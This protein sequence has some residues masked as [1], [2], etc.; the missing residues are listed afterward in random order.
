MP[1]HGTSGR[2]KRRWAARA[3]VAAASLAVV[4]AL[5]AVPNASPAYANAPVVDALDGS[6]VSVESVAAGR[7]D[8]FT[9]G[10]DGA[11]HQK[12]YVNGVWSGWE[13]LGGSLS[14]AP[15]VVAWA[16][17][18]NVFARSTSNT[19]VH[20]W[21]TGGAWSEWEDLGGTLTSAPSAASWGSGHIDV[22]ARG[23]DNALVHKFY[24]RG[25]SS[26]SSLGGAL[27]SA[28]SAI[29]W[30]TGRLDVFARSTGSTLTHWWYT[31]DTWFGSEDLGGS[32]TSAPAAASWT[33][34]RL[35]VFGRGSSNTLAH[36]WFTDGVWSSWEAFAGSLT[37]APSA[38]SWGT[39]RIDVF[40][41]DT[42]G[43]LQQK[44]YTGQ[45]TGW[46]RIAPF[47]PAVPI[48]SNSRTSVFQTSPGSAV[49]GTVE[50]AYT[51]NIGRLLHV[52]QTNPGDFN[53]AQWTVLSGNEAFSGQ[54]A[55]AQQ[56]DGRVQVAGHN[57][58]GDVWLRTQTQAGSPGWAAAV[59]AGGWM[60]STAT[61][62]TLSDGRL[63]M[64]AVD[65][66]GRLWYKQQSTVNGV[67]GTWQSL[68]DIDLAT[69]PT[70]A[71]SRNGLQLFGV[72]TGG[73]LRTAE[74]TSGGTVS[75]WTTLHA[76]STTG[77]PAVVVYPGFLTRVFVRTSDGAVVTKLQDSTG[78]W[79][80]S[81]QPTGTF[82]SVGSPA[83][84]LDPV[85]GRTAVVVR[86][87]DNEVYV[88]WETAQAS[89]AWGGWARAIR[90]T[91][92]TFSDPAVTDPSV[93]QVATSSGQTWI[94]VFRTI[95]DET[96]VYQRESQSA[97]VA[98][99]QAATA[100]QADF[101][102]HTLPAPPA[103]SR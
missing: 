22:F 24:L 66:D 43:D 64:F 89:G 53:L 36:R 80:A 44:T 5:V 100:G 85:L 78:S 71:V 91:D 1:E 86:G 18:F 77:T 2:T 29:S 79:P 51:D 7:L 48:Q 3:L 94:I 84:I 47:A 56:A 13:D 54:P 101:T 10:P 59:D 40:T 97:G 61:V 98:S 30:G 76:S 6:V 69:A 4:A 82:S 75:A 33:A 65:V 28:P 34:G 90:P 45:W 19:L 21:Y 9:R 32:L 74:Y 46:Q 42:A 70:V 49:L 23:S 15:S 38:T 52:R 99:A 50:Y 11:L 39:N 96:R 81:W 60:T 72:N 20:R 67:Y 93:A 88:N 62:G 73:A 92:P 12:S 63:V 87:T 68:G 57:T 37:S 17:G 27:S 95:N 26:W 25:W 31:K 8:L 14:S 55:L 103:G 58:N 16:D 102:A 35:D 83:A 41:T